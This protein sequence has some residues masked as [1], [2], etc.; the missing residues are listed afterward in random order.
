MSQRLRVSFD[1][2]YQPL[3]WGLLLAGLIIR[4]EFTA[5]TLGNA[6]D[7]GS[8]QLVAKLLVSEPGHVYKLANLPGQNPRWPY[9]PGYFPVVMLFHWLAVHTHHQFVKL[10]RVPPAL[11]DLGIAWVVQDHLRFRGAG[12]GPRLAAA[13]LVAL[14]PSFIAISGIHGQIDSVGI[15]PAVIALSVWERAPIERRAW[16]A[17]LLIGLG[18]DIKVVP[19]L[20]LLALLPSAR[21]RREALTLIAATLV[22]PL[23]SIIPVLAAAG[24]GWIGPLAQYHGGTGLGGISL[25]V[26]PSLALNWLHV[27]S[28]PEN[29]VAH[30]FA[31][32]GGVIAL[33]AIAS[34]FV[35][36]VRRRLP[37]ETA[38]ILIWLAVYALGIQFFLQ[39][40]VWGLPFMLLAGYLWQVTAL[41]ALLFLPTLIT[42]HHVRHAWVAYVFYVVP[43][44]IV[45]IVET[46][47]LGVMLRKIFRGDFDRQAAPS[48]AQPVVSVVGAPGGTAR[49]RT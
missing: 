26:Q 19:G 44:I 36:A 17:G 12:H 2:R 27:G 43:M 31:L 16:I 10:I 23:L 33:V 49:A 11:T 15:L 4:V 3:L 6:Y 13:A 38:A 9:L 45:W 35:V 39:Y 47:A 20:M 32:H 40:M 18:A 25:L 37:A 34:A 28:T 29:G 41:Q 22:I 1:R 30:W 21:S 8:L 5:H 46:T 14:G 42:Y 48:A 24:V 7:L